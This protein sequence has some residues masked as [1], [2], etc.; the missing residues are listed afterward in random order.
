MDDN[1]IGISRSSEGQRWQKYLKDRLIGNQVIRIDSIETIQKVEIEKDFKRWG[2]RIWPNPNIYAKIVALTAAASLG[3]TGAQPG[4]SFIQDGIDE[5]RIVA[6]SLSDRFFGIPTETVEVSKTVLVEQTQTRN[7]PVTKEVTRELGR[8]STN[9]SGEFTPDINLLNSISG[10][11]NGIA[12]SRGEILSIVVQGT[13]SDEWGNPLTS[14]GVGNIGNVEL[15]QERADEIAHILRENA[16][17]DGLTLPEIQTQANEAIL[18]PKDLETLENLAVQVGFGSSARL[19]N[20]YKENPDQLPPVAR[21]FLDIKFGNTRG[22]TISVSYLTTE[23]EIEEVTVVVP[24]EV[25]ETYE[26]E[27]PRD[28]IPPDPTHDYSPNP[29]WLIPPPL[30]I[31]F[32]RKE[33][34][35]VIEERAVTEPI[36]DRVWLKLYPE[37]LREGNTLDKD[38]WALTR[39]YQHLMKED[40]IKSILRYDYLDEDGKEQTL[41][42]AFVDHEPSKQSIAAIE[43]TL[44]QAC[45]LHGG[46]IA[47]RLGLISIFPEDSAGEQIDI[48]KIGLGIDEQYPKGVLGVATPAIGLIELHMDIDATTGEIRNF[49]GMEWTLAHEITHFADVINQEMQLHS[50]PSVPNGFYTT[51]PWEQHGL[52]MYISLASEGYGDPKW[53]I[54]VPFYDEDGQ[55]QLETI[56]VDELPENYATWGEIRKMGFPTRYSTTQEGE[57]FAE[58]GAAVITGIPI[59]FD[60]HPPSAGVPDS[61]AAEQ[62]GYRVD[63]RLREHFAKTVGAN[64]VFNPV[65]SKLRWSIDYDPDPSISVGNPKVVDKHF[66]R[67]IKDAKHRELP[68]DSELLNVLAGVRQSFG[69]QQ[70]LHSTPNQPSIQLRELG[71]SDLVR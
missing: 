61:I 56:V 2:L 13:S 33:K 54:S 51:N 43:R 40:R 15:A 70:R 48:E 50:V 31:P 38:A 9:Q 41:R 71:N 22:V 27:V 36:E 37:A 32:R 63:P 57:L 7:V 47:E 53:H 11:L 19:L 68:Q 20:E 35:V 18:G 59:G 26:I 30:P 23:M 46:K 5:A 64:P 44:E 8:Q 16:Q 42:V 12:N 21:D 58:T 62:V 69:P 14:L 55:P 10:E 1:T 3:I 65:S 17:R 29:I 39:K 6:D 24:V 28:I 67:L 25:L 52:P 60:E 4:L 34:G 45:K 49:S 66:A